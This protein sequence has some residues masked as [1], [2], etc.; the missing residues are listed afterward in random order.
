VEVGVSI[1]ALS[2]THVS[3][4]YERGTAPILD[5]VT[6]QIA[7]GEHVALIGLNGSGKTSLLM[8]AVGLVPH[9]GAIE[10]CGIAVTPKTLTEVRDRVGF[11][12]NVP[13]DQLLFP[14]VLDDVAFALLRR[15]MQV[16]EA[17]AT[18]EAVLDALGIGHL[19][20]ASLHH[21]SHG[22]QQRVALAGALVSAPPIL[23]LDEPSAALDPPAKHQL[24]RLLQSQAAAMLVATH[25][26]D[27]AR[28]FCTRFV[29]LDKA[30]IAF[31]GTDVEP[32]LQVWSPPPTGRL[33][34]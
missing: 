15:G 25:D 7:P 33:P 19:R 11:L 12:F 9:A 4:R 26:L 31:D 10:V 24:A 3:V 28:R 8:A 27:F 2:C 18:A 20:D 5:D 1:A 22:Q 6:F 13:E 23:L 30:R 16:S 21:L 34:R 17:A 14:R 32:I 29:L